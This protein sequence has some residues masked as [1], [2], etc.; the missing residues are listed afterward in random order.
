MT[1]VGLGNLGKKYIATR[2]N[3]G[4]IVVEAFW[5]INKKKF[6]PWKTKGDCLISRGEV[7]NTPITLVLPQNFMN[8]SGPALLSAIKKDNLDNLLVVHDELDVPFGEMKLQTDRSAAG[9]N[10][11][12]S[13]ID[14][15][16]TQNFSRLRLGI[17]QSPRPA[18]TEKFVLEKFTKEEREQLPNIIKKA[19]SSILT[20]L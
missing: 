10:G 8:N 2:H 11:V 15:L 7:N 12:Q 16:G 6:E 14:T 3:F 20:K 4:F 9:H 13:I 17:G 5:K 18:E 1:I 19:I